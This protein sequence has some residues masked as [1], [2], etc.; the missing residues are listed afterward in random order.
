MT[1]SDASRLQ[2]KKNKMQLCSQR[3]RCRV[4]RP[5]LR[6]VHT[7][8]GSTSESRSNTYENY[9][10]A[11]RTLV[12]DVLDRKHSATVDSMR[13]AISGRNSDGPVENFTAVKATD[14]IVDAAKKMCELDIGSLLVV[15]E[16]G[17]LQ[18]IVTERDYLRKVVAADNNEESWKDVTVAAIMTNHSKLITVTPDSDLLEAVDLISRHRF[19]HLPVITSESKGSKLISSNGA[20]AGVPVGLL[21]SKDV[22]MEMLKFHHAQVKHLLE[23]VPFRIW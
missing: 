16:D 14:S 19:R 3:V 23:Y 9:T 21:S 6:F 7:Y 15:G 10:R 4:I 18:G 12:R 22:S 11:R 8:N 5:G 2:N 17:F 20:H 1:V 13:K